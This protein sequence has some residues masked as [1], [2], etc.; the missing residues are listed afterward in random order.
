MRVYVREGEDR[1]GVEAD[2]FERV[3]DSL[4]C[5]NRVRINIRKANGRLPGNGN[6]N[7]HGAVHLII[8]ALPKQ[9]EHHHTADFKRHLLNNPEIVYPEGPTVGS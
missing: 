3:L 5:R 6:S 7:S 1:V 8:S 4:L 2:A 9:A